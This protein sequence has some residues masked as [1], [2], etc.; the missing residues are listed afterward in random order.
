[1]VPAEG[2]LYVFYSDKPMVEIDN[3][4]TL[5]H[6]R[7]KLMFTNTTGEVS[8]TTVITVKLNPLLESSGK[9][10]IWYMFK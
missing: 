10:H 4:F 5:M 8:K 7:F 1:M 9:R 6:M 2:F 3:P